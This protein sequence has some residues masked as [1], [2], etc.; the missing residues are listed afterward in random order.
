VSSCVFHG[1]TL[2]DAHGPGVLD[3][4]AH[5]VLV[6]R[7]E[8][9]VGPV[10]T[11]VGVARQREFLGL[12]LHERGTPF[13]GEPEAHDAAVTGEGDVDNPPDPEL[14]A[15]TNMRLVAARQ[16]EGEHADIV[17]GHHVDASVLRQ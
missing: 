12:G 13:L 7:G 4:V 3:E 15:A 6:D 10:V 9:H 1:D 17:D 14:D 2:R 11:H 8:A 5:L 16:G